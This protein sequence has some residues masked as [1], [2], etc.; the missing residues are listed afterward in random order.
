MGH[1]RHVTGLLYLFFTCTGSASWL[2]CEQFKKYNC[3]LLPKFRKRWLLCVETF[4]TKIH[5]LLIL[6]RTR[7]NCLNTIPFIKTVITVIIEACHCHQLQR[8]SLNFKPTAWKNSRNSCA[9][10]DIMTNYWSQTFCS[11]GY[12]TVKGEKTGLK[13]GHA[14]TVTYLQLD[15]FPYLSLGIS[16]CLMK[17]FH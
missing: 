12:W 17:A 5:N 7:K 2:C 8:L 3:Q 6:F 14:Q 16:N 15:V 10:L 13:L 1:T 9:D 4:C 11:R